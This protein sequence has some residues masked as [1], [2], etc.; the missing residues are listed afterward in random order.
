MSH[1]GFK[2]TE[3]TSDKLDRVQRNPTFG[4]VK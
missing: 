1:G 4:K 2:V 3:L